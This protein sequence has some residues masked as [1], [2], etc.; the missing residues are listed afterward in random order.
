MTKSLLIAFVTFLSC[1]FAWS[2]PSFK[3]DPSS[4]TEID[5]VLHNGTEP[6]GSYLAMNLPFEPFEK[7]RLALEKK[8]GHKLKHRDEAHITVIT[9]IEFDTVLK[10]KLSID[11]IN[12]FALLNHI[13]KA[14]PQFLCIGRGQKKNPDGKMLETFYVVVESQKL[15]EIRK[16][17]AEEF[18]RAGGPEGEFPEDLFFPHVTL[19][20]TERDLHYDDGI[21]KD[22]KSCFI[23]LVAQ[24]SKAKD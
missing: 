24:K 9:P 19:G 8:L 14:E 18:I 4:V 3:Y 21:K 1:Q 11:K 17:V 2:K 15:K 23:N 7:L 10:N 12:S 22:Q 5:F 13:Q 20:F 16:K 6:M